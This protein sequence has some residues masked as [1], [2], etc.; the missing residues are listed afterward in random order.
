[1][2]KK[3][4]SDYSP[5]YPLP[6]KNVSCHLTGHTKRCRAIVESCICPKYMELKG[7]NPQTGEDMS[8]WGCSDTFLPFI[9]LQTD[10]HSIQLVAAMENQTNEMY[11]QDMGIRRG[12]ELAVQEAEKRNQLIAAEVAATQRIATLEEYKA[13]GKAIED[14]SNIKVIESK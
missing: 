2:F 4:T 12:L 1:M 10:M 14:H 9:H 8:N 7:K 5:T 3:N 13:V 11:K 6:D